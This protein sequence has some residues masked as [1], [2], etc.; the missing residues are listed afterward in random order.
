MV[1][2]SALQYLDL[3][4]NSL[5]FEP[6]T[7][8]VIASLACGQSCDGLPTRDAL[9]PTSCSA[10]GPAPLYPMPGHVCTACDQGEI[11][12]LAILSVA[13]GGGV[14]L[15]F[16]LLS[17]LVLL[18]PAALTQWIST[19]TIVVNHVQSVTVVA[20]LQLEGPL[21]LTN[22]HALLTL[23]VPRLSEAICILRTSEAMQLARWLVALVYNAAVVVLFV[24]LLCLQWL[25]RRAGKQR[26]ADQLE[27]LLSVLYFLQLTTTWLLCLRCF[28]DYQLKSKLVSGTQMEGTS[29]NVRCSGS[30]TNPVHGRRS[31]CDVTDWCAVESLREDSWPP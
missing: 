25:V 19:V 24:A 9:P 2:S 8:E 22:L 31:L 16:C 7:P 21:L 15:V 6:S 5:V 29:G 3:S 13:V 26:R 18:Q 23:Y 4:H 1:L 10:F 20:S 28:G 27:Q 30:A 17:Y 11:T 14:L 12:H